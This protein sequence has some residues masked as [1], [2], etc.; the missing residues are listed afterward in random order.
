MDTSNFMYLLVATILVLLELVYF[1]VAARFR[2]IDKPNERS[3]H[4]LPTIRGGGVIFIF[5]ALL[6]SVWYGGAFPL[7]MLA[8]VL[9]GT[10]SFI[11]DIKSLPNWLRFLAH[12]C[13]GLLILGEVGLFGLPW[14]Y[15]VAILVMVIGIINAYN[16]MD[17]INGITGF[18]SLAILLPLYL[19][20]PD[21]NVKELQLFTM[22]GLVVFLFFNARTKA[23]CF[24]GDVGS[25]SIAVLVIFFL[26]TR[27]NQSQNV[28][29][30]AFLLLYGVDTILTII[31]RLY[32]RENI[33]KA[34][35]RHLF[36]LYSNEYKTPHLIVSAAY[37]LVQFAVN[38]FII[39][40]ESS[41]YFLLILILST[42]FTYIGLKVIALRGISRK[43]H[44]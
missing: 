16:F 37:G 31:Q 1:A 18:Y 22:I 21:P 26:A 4:T 2:I 19:T 38:W 28:N 12:L 6:F 32:L 41:P 25:V 9:S 43:Q 13:S 34:H 39:K 23:R 40:K 10:V 33:F 11:D 29:Y 36:Q 14:M 3:S 30:I 5:A 15:L 20:E 7:L 42:G 44:V 8:V 27:I 17:G 35:R 24:A